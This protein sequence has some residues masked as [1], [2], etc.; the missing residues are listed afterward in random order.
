MSMHVLELT[1]SSHITSKLHSIARDTDKSMTLRSG[2]LQKQCAWMERCAT[3]GDPYL[4]DI[5]NITVQERITSHL[6]TSFGLLA[7]RN[8]NLSHSYFKVLDLS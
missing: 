1:L 2:T 5:K 7:T 4:C 6:F 8:R 3:S